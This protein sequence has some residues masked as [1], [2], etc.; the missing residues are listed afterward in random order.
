MGG[1]CSRRKLMK[2]CSCPRRF[3]SGVCAHRS[4]ASQT[5]NLRG[6]PSLPG[7]FFGR[8]ERGRGRDTGAGRLF[9]PQVATSS[10][11]RSWALCERSGNAQV[12]PERATYAVHSRPPPSLSC[13]IKEAGGG[14][15]PRK[16]YFVRNNTS[17]E[18]H[19]SSRAAPRRYAA[20]PRSTTASRRLSVAPSRRSSTRSKPFVPP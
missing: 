10:S 11:G 20:P 17:K 13:A 5:I 6:E 3:F 9:T 2:Y 16:G 8:G 4:R 19:T 14:A 7:H 18:I 12:R 1:A 15:V